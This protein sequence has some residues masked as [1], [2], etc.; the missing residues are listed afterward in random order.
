MWLPHTGRN[1]ILIAQVTSQ[2]ERRRHR[3]EG[4][5]QLPELSSSFDMV[6]KCIS[7]F[8]TPF[9]VTLIPEQRPL[10]GVCHQPLSA[11]LPKPLSLT[12]R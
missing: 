10:L 1:S 3:T 9:L 8:F 5:H 4:Q 2:G 12:E 6:Q 7:Q 11:F